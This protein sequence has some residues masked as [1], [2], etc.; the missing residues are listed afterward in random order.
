MGIPSSFDLADFPDLQS[1]LGNKVP[2]V[3]IYVHEP[4]KIEPDDE[5]LVWRVNMDNPAGAWKEPTKS[6]F[7]T[8]I[9]LW[10]RTIP[11]ITRFAK[12]WGPLGLDR[13]ELFGPDYFEAEFRESIETWRYFSRRAFC[14]L[15]VAADLRQGRTAKSEHWAEL[16]SGDEWTGQRRQRSNVRDWAKSSLHAQHLLLGGETDLWLKYSGLGFALST[17][18]GNWQL[19]VNYDNGKLIAAIALQL[20]LTA[21]GHTLYVCSECQH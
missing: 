21:S 20:A 5:V 12:A 15:S 17:D 14:V 11:Q 3:K 19:E 4:V 8:F 2:L 16:T 9:Q 1:R 7:N 18:K 6:M 10:Q 13:P